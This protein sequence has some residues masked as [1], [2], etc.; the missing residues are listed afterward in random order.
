MGGRGS[1]RHFSHNCATVSDGLQLDVRRWQR[2]GLLAAERSFTWQWTRAG[3]VVGSINVRTEPGRRVILSYLTRRDDVARENSQYSISIS[4]TS[5]NYGGERAW[6]LC[7]VRGCGRRVAILYGVQVF[8]CRHCY[9]LAYRTQ[10]QSPS[11]RALR[12]AQAIRLR[13]GGSGNMTEPF[14]RKP[15]GMHQRTYE[16]LC[17]KEAAAFERHRS[18]SGKRQGEQ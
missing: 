7:S 6:F 18:A 10:R 2:D 8:A 11:V 17:G 15:K 12:Q 16:R 5:C 4:W 1:G 9:R 13:L 14:P 3:E